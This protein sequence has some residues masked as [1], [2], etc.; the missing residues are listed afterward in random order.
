MKNKLL[1]LT[2]AL[3]FSVMGFAQNDAINAFFKQYETNEKFTLVSISPKMFK[4]MTKVK[5]DDVEPKVKTLISNLT[6]FRLIA[7]EENC[8]QY[9]NE[10]IKKFNF[11]SYEEILTVRDKNENVRFFTK[12]NGNI[13]SELVMLV[14]GKDNFVLMCL[15][16][17]IDLDSIGQ[18]GAN[19]NVKGLDNLKA[20]KPKK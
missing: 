14:G 13:I 16:G 19:V 4:M 12:E 9:Y 18:L 1:A 11:T 3:F 10:A 2:V 17:N 8:L 20:L 15:T 7:T 5:W 6:S